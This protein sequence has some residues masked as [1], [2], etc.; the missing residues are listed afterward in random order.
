M[1]RAPES[2]FLDFRWHE[3][4]SVCVLWSP[5]CRA[6]K[7]NFHQQMNFDVKRGDILSILGLFSYYNGCEWC[8]GKMNTVKSMQNLVIIQTFSAFSGIN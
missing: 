4:A 2:V 3:E 1:D 5:S 7:I 6:V 8:I